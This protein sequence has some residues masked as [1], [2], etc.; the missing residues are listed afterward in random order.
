MTTCGEP[1]VPFDGPRPPLALVAAALD[2]V[3]PLIRRLGL[4]GRFPSFRGVRASGPVTLTIT[5]PGADRA[6]AVVE[7]LLAEQRPSGIILLGFAAG[8]D[9]ALGT[10]RLIVCRRL[11]DGSGAAFDLTGGV[12]VPATD[13]PRQRDPAGTLLTVPRLVETPQAKRTLWQTYRA[14]VADMESFSIA[15]IAARQGVGLTVVRS[16]SDAADTALPPGIA[17]WLKPDG[18]A[19]VGAVAGDLLRHPALLGQVLRL[20]RHSRAAAAALADWADAELARPANPWQ[21]SPGE[22]Q[23]S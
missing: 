11:I 23:Q 19:A 18:R 15:S 21:T 13:S 9:P 12:P 2:E 8:L 5:G 7:S 14:A 16:V 22:H 20:A 1:S 3:R 6:A 17:R 4:A 10:G